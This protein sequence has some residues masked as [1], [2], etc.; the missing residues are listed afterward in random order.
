MKIDERKVY[1]IDIILFI[2]LF[3]FL[4]T[5]VSYVTSNIDSWLA[6]NQ[7][8]ILS[9]IFY[10]YVLYIIL[11]CIIGSILFIKTCY[12]N[13]INLSFKL[14]FPIYNIIFFILFFIIIILGIEYYL[15]LVN[16]NLLR[17]YSLNIFGVI[18]NEKILYILVILNIFIN[19]FG[20][21]MQ[22]LYTNYK[23]KIN[24][25]VNYVITYLTII[26][27]L[28]LNYFLIIMVISGGD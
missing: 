9:N 3:I 10:I 24:K 26:I 4:F 13:E 20:L 12:K 19:L 2:G 8:K 6:S 27:I 18:F 23:I 21:P 16:Y 22:L 1:L 28:Y 15:R 17:N 5:F 14:L 7:Y 11:K 25:I